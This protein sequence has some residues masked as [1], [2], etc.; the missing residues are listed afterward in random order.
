MPERPGGAATTT[1]DQWLGG[2]LMLRQPKKGHRV[3]SDA[4]LLAAAAPAATWIVDV[5][6]G[7]GAVGLAIALRFPEARVDLIEI[8]P[9]LSALA[10]E[11]AAAN[12]L[13]ARARVV[14]ADATLARSRRAGG[15]K[16][17]EADLVVT[18]PP[19]FEAD[20]VRASPEPGRAQAHVLSDEG[21]AAH[22]GI[23]AW[24]RG[25]LA[26]L[27]PSGRFVMIHR[28]DALA[29]I[30]A[31]LEGRL[32]AIAILPIHPRADT[33][34]HRLLIAGI[35]GARAP[36]GIRPGLVLHDAAGGFTPRVEALHRGEAAI[37]WG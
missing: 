7:V 15:L 13:G 28:P 33:P 26:L 32:G 18:N 17:G 35:K 16:D 1:V 9:E 31:A 2:R 36:L 29:V 27:R 12:G 23:E 19:F 14:T 8:D 3:G 20:K 24:I 37:D 22:R 5:G 11:N 30:L 10:M 4:A 34:A 21:D 25:A 6:A